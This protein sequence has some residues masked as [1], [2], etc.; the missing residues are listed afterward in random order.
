MALN[1]VDRVKRL[2]EQ[3]R[4]DEESWSLAWQLHQQRFG[5]SPDSSR[6][7]LPVDLCQNEFVS[8]PLHMRSTSSEH[9]CRLWQAASAAP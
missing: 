8:A 3:S 4:L 6:L 9:L 7:G 2:E 1:P 5:A